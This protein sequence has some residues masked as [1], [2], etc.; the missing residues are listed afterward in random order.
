MKHK[1]RFF[2]NFYSNFTDSALKQLSNTRFK[3]GTLEKYYKKLG[4]ID[5][6]EF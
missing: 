6:N 3:L 2:A 1:L 5:E 4:F